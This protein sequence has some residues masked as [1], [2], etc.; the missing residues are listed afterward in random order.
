M[1]LWSLCEI[2]R[3]I[4][5][6]QELAQMNFITLSISCRITTG[7]TS[8]RTYA[9]M[10]CNACIPFVETRGYI[11]AH[12][13][14]STNKHKHKIHILV[15]GKIRTRHIGRLDGPQARVLHDG[16][17][18]GAAERELG[19]LVRRVGHLVG[20]LVADLLAILLGDDALVL[21]LVAVLVDL[22]GLLGGGGRGLL[23]LDGG[24]GSGGRGIGLGDD[25]RGGRRC[26]LFL[27]RGHV[28][29]ALLG[30]DGGGGGGGEATVLD[31]LA[32]GGVEGTGRRSQSA[33]RAVVGSNSGCE[34]CGGGNL[35]VSSCHLRIGL[36]LLGGRGGGDGATGLDG[37]RGGIHDGRIT[38]TNGIINEDAV[39]G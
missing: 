22:D 18:M 9:Y 35:V 37:Q 27:G 31:L 3:K 26:V 15:V 32:G 12:L 39:C 11:C 4:C 36:G 5:K 33:R 34:H 8:K 10:H 7:I 17:G 29:V 6:M 2:R 19:G 23:L 24:G 30:L 14:T 13:I 28:V 16:V 1:S 38:M 21:H 25:G 20:I